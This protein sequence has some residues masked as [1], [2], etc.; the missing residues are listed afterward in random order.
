[1]RQEGEE[2]K[3]KLKDVE[4]KCD[5]VGAEIKNTETQIE[6]KITKIEK[7]SQKLEKLRSNNEA[8]EL[9]PTEMKVS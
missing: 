4:G 5:Q 1:M 7:L 6:L 2:L 3:I 9:S 8:S